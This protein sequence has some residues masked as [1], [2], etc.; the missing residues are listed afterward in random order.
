MTIEWGFEP[1][2]NQKTSKNGFDVF[3]GLDGLSLW[4]A[5]NRSGEVWRWADCLFWCAAEVQL[6]S[7]RGAGQQE[8][9]TCAGV[10]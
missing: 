9:N 7:G 5:V 3:F 8:V 4:Q 1:L 2:F 10:L 6:V